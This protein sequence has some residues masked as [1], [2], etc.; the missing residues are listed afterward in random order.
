MNIV[1]IAVM[2]FV[3]FGIYKVAKSLL[4]LLISV[5]FI[6]IVS[7]IGSTL[8]VAIEGYDFSNENQNLESVKVSHIE[9]VELGK[10]VH[11]DMYKVKFVGDSKTYKLDNRTL[12]WSILIGRQDQEF[13]DH[14]SNDGK[15]KKYPK[16]ND[17]LLQNLFQMTKL[18]MI[19]AFGSLVD[20]IKDRND[21]N[22]SNTK[23]VAEIKAAD[24][25]EEPPEA[26]LAD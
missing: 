24:E 5:G 21:D 2:L 17:I 23:K 20:N 25:S 3:A 26:I 9:T 4:S 16:F 18:S 14:I 19:Q 15:F 10:T 6:L 12:Y 13:F 11:N 22:E 1:L 7:G 8:Y